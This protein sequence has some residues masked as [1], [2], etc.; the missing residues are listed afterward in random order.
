MRRGHDAH[1]LDHL[2]LDLVVRDLVGDRRSA[3]RIDWIMASRMA[4]VASVIS[5]PACDLSRTENMPS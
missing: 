4:R 3:S 2:A 1:Q 5:G